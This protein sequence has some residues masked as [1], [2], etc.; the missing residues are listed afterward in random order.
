MTG[1]PTNR[2]NHM[3]SQKKHILAKR[4]TGYSIPSIHKTLVVLGLPNTHT[5]TQKAKK[6]GLPNTHTQKENK[7]SKFRPKTDFSP[8]LAYVD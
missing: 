8:C 7:F 3:S 6:Q 4:H 1:R 5:H 2:E